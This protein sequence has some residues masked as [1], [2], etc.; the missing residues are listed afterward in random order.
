MKSVL[1]SVTETIRLPATAIWRPRATVSTS[2]SSG[3]T[4]GN[5]ASTSNQEYSLCS[6]LQ[7]VSLHLLVIIRIGRMIR[8]HHGIFLERIERDLNG[9]FQLCVVASSDGSWIVLDF[10]IRRDAVIF[11]FPFAV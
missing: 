10:D 9:F 3:I 4:C 7:R 2:G 5:H 8:N 6:E 11:D 1:P